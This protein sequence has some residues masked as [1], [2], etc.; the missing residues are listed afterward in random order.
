LWGKAFTFAFGF[1]AVVNAQ[2]DVGFFSLPFDKIYDFFSQIAYNQIANEQTRRSQ[3]F[4]FDLQADLAQRPQD[5]VHGLTYLKGYFSEDV[6]LTSQERQASEARIDQILSLPAH[7]LPG[8]SIVLLKSV[9]R[10]DRRKVLPRFGCS[11]D[12]IQRL[13]TA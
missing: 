1:M 7:E 13:F 3:D 12:F 4:W 6:S 2:V 5:I 8:A 10:H 9:R 11:K